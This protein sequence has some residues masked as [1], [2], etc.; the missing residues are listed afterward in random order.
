MDAQLSKYRFGL[1]LQLIPS[2]YGFIR[3]LEDGVIRWT[4]CKWRFKYS[5]D[6]SES[7]WNYQNN[8]WKID[9]ANEE[10]VA[11]NRFYAYPILTEN[12][13]LQDW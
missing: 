5:L 8:Y 11:I 13:C 3:D 4:L 7:K 10:Q 9:D 6:L 2:T 1:T 12:Q